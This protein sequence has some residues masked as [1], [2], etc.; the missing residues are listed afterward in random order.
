MFERGNQGRQQRTTSELKVPETLETTKGRHSVDSGPLDR[1][2]VK[3]IKTFDRIIVPDDSSS[4][5][6]GLPTFDRTVIV[7][8]ENDGS[9]PDRG[10]GSGTPRGQLVFVKVTYSYGL[11][12]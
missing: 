9:R 6:R 11:F 7:I 12:W 4:C 10:C 5:R 1:N 8:P 3:E 2:G